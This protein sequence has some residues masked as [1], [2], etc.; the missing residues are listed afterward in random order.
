MEYGSRQS[1]GSDS[2]MAMSREE[3]LPD[4]YPAEADESSSDSEVSMQ[5]NKQR[6]YVG[7]NFDLRGYNYFDIS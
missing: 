5:C 7:V 4:E 1:S 6:D 2:S 3:V